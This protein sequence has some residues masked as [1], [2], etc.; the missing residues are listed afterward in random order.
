MSIELHALQRIAVTEESNVNF[1]VDLTGSAT[2]LDVPFQEGTAQL[3]LDVDILRPN[4]VQQ[5]IDSQPRNVIGPRGA[6][7]TLTMI[8][9]PTGNNSGTSR[10][11]T[12]AAL[13]QLLKTFYGGA[14]AS[15]VGTT[16][17]GGTAAA[18]TVTSAAGFA[19]GGAIGWADSDG[20]VHLHEIDNVASTT[21]NLHQQFPGAPSNGNT[22]R[23]ATTIFLTENP[24]TSVQF[25]VEGAEQ[26]DRWLLL[27]GQLTAAPT[28]AI[29]VGGLP[30]VTFTIGFAYWK[31]LTGAAITPAT[32]A[33]FDPQYFEGFVRLKAYDSGT[34]RTLY[35]VAAL[36][37]EQQGPVYVPVASPSGTAPQLGGRP[38]KRW[39]RNRAVPIA[40]FGMSVPFESTD[41]FDDRDTLENFHAEVQ[42]NT[43]TSALLITMPRIELV[44]TQRIDQDGLAYQQLSFEA[45]NDG[46]TDDASS[47][48]ERSALRLH[49]MG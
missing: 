48:M 46:A 32:Y 34:A 31:K 4:T 47:E 19:A 27:G 25:I 9:A 20:I 8:L 6:T 40:R 1:C 3:A 49:F 41:W 38:A 42:I 23:A 30:T 2:Y 11:I 10:A 17:T 12:D 26:D 28:F 44:N 15:N 45:T 43:G 16:F 36:T 13:L 39:R 7:L 29:P 14:D 18:P 37:W 33:N 24:D 22:A 5:R 21:I 35:D